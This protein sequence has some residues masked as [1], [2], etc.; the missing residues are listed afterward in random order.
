MHRV[1]TGMGF[2]GYGYGFLKTRV[3]VNLI[4]LVLVSS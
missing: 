2:D 3:L 1:L 4:I